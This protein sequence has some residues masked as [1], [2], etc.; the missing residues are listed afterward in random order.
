MITIFRC[1]RRVTELGYLWTSCPSP[2]TRP[3]SWKIL[4]RARLSCSITITARYKVVIKVKSQRLEQLRKIKLKWARPP[5]RETSSWSSLWKNLQKSL[6]ST[7]TRQQRQN[8]ILEWSKWTKTDCLTCNLF[9]RVLI[10]LRLRMPIQLKSNVIV[11]PIKQEQPKFLI[12]SPL[13]N[14]CQLTLG[15]WRLRQK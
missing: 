5:S 4:W 3:Q 9:F 2:Q 6:I 11:P 1:Q 14:E 8:R 12:Q 10:P 13:S 7:K 15:P